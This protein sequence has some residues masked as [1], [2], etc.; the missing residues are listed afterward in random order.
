MIFDGQKLGQVRSWVCPIFRLGQ[1]MGQP[2]LKTGAPSS[3]QGLF[4]RW[5]RPV[6]RPG[7]SEDGAQQIDTIPETVMDISFYHYI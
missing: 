4:G 2:S 7:R 5:G 6:L 3:N 1:K